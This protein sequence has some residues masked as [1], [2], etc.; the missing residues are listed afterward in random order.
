MFGKENHILEILEYLPNLDE[1]IQREREII[2]EKLLIDPLCMNLSKG[3]NCGFRDPEKALLAQKAGG[4]ARIEGLLNCW[5]EKRK[6]DRE[7][8]ERWRNSLSESNKGNKNPFYGLTHSEA[9]L[10]KM[11][12][13]KESNKGENHNQFGNVWICNEETLLTKSV[14]KEELATYLK[15]G[16]R[17]G[18]K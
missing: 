10:F 11:K 15:N 9:T 16:W 14:K 2:N 12:S 4:E 17:K 8:N 5:W 7:L 3:G 18:R 6:T 13:A 1:L